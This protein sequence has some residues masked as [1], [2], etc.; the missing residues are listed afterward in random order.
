MYQGTQASFAELIGQNSM[1]LT[2]LESGR[3]IP[4]RDLV[5]RFGDALRPGFGVEFAEHVL[6]G[7]EGDSEELALA[8]DPS[9]VGDFHAMLEALQSKAAQDRKRS[10]AKSKVG[11]SRPALTSSSPEETVIKRLGDALPPG[12]LQPQGQVSLGGGPPV[13]LDLIDT[14]NRLAFEIKSIPPSVMQSESLYQQV[15]TTCIGLAQ[16]LKAA[17]HQLVVVTLQPVPGEFIDTLS[18][19]GVSVIWPEPSS[20]TRFS[21]SDSVVRLLNP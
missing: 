9:K 16:I 11:L 6:D 2:N 20:T 1:G 10:P 3:K 5:R 13:F 4:T 14:T 12:Y 15:L 17:K 18:E 7:P 19:F 21:G 8:L